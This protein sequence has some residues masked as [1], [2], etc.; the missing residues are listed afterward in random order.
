MSQQTPVSLLTPAGRIKLIEDGIYQNYLAYFRKAEDT[1]RWK[2]HKDIP[3]HL[4][5]PN[6]DDDVAIIV[7]GFFA[8]ESYLPDYVTE[9]MQMVR[10]SR[11][12][13]WFQANWGYEESKH[14]MAWE[15]WLTTS[16]KRTPAQMEEYAAYLSEKQWSLPYDTPRRMIIYQMIQERATYLNYHNLAARAER[17]NDQALATALRIVAVDEIAHHGFFYKGVQLYLKYDTAATLDDILH[18]LKTFGMPAKDF[19]YNVSEFEEAVYKAGIYGPREYIKDVQ[20]PI[21]SALGYNSRRELERAALRLRIAPDGIG[22]QDIP[23]WA[24][25]PAD[26]PADA[27]VTTTGD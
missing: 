22:P 5:N 7:E 10:R 14:A 3:W 9:A 15:T 1:R 19:L 16:G 6:I 23:D 17:D 18:I 25:E 24:K 2:L 27:L 12:R 26:R 21:L 4:A 11:G 13:A 8:V 20:N